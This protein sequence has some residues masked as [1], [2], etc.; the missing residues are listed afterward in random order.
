MEGHAGLQDRLVFD[1][2]RRGPFAPVGRIAETDGIATAAFAEDPVFLQHVDQRLGDVAGSI[3]SAGRV[4]R[5]LDPFKLGLLG[6]A[7]F[8]RWFAQ[9]HGPAQRRMVTAIAARQFEKGCLALAHRI[10]VPRQ[11]C[12][13]RIKT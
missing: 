11:M 9:E 12:G 10:A 7:H 3:T 4:Q 8:F 5:R 2:D 1:P 6:I 13:C